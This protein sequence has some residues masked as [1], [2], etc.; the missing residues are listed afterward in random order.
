MKKK[1]PVLSKK[2]LL[3][4]HVICNLKQVTGGDLTAGPECIQP[5]TAPISCHAGCVEPVATAQGGTMCGT[6]NPSQVSCV[7]GPGCASA[8]VA[9]SA[10]SLCKCPGH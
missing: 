9:C 10:V 3:G 4:K 8:A 1:N 2:L 7:V 5:I 6:M